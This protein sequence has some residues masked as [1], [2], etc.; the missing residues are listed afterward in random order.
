MLKGEGSPNDGFVKQWITT[1]AGN[2]SQRR[3]GTNDIV[4]SLIVNVE[5]L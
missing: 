3:I 5:G 4:K 2:D 1:C